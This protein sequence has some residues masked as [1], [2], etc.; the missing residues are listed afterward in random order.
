[1]HLQATGA[2]GLVYKSVR[3]PDGECVGLFY[4]D[5]ATNPVQGRHLDYHWN[6]KSVDFYRD[7]S[8]H[9]VYRIVY[10]APNPLCGYDLEVAFGLYPLSARALSTLRT[11]VDCS[12]A[13][14]GLFIFASPS[15]LATWPRT[16]TAVPRTNA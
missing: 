8:T 16:L 3:F 4:P 12:F 7:A 5:L 11:L 15:V 10:S 9:Q 1:A 6:G 2:E 13:P 14:L